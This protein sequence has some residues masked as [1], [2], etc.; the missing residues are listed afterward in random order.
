MRGASSGGSN[1]ISSFS[2]I[3]NINSLDKINSQPNA[4]A[5][6]NLPNKLQINVDDVYAKTSKQPYIHPSVIPLKLM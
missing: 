4:T 2:N 5:R 3:S 6:R 1:L